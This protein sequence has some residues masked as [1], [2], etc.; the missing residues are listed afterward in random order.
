M[1]TGCF[2]CDIDGIFLDAVIL[3]GIN[4]VTGAYGYLVDFWV[5]CADA[6]TVTAT[7]HIARPVDD[8]IHTPQRSIQ[9]EDLQHNK[10]TTF[11][12]RVY[13]VT[14]FFF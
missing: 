4:V 9:N 2:G 13:Y 6:Q 14:I 5:C 7:H 3:S 12:N 10:V 1:I 11:K 8:M